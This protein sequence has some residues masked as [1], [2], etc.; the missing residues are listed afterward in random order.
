VS[1]PPKVERKITIEHT[2]NFDAIVIILFAA[3]CVW[4][5]GGYLIKAWAEAHTE[6]GK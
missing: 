5:V 2:F 6:Q 4:C 3:F 1:E